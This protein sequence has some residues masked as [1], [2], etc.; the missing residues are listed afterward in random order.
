MKIK[1]VLFL[2]NVNVE[3]EHKMQGVVVVE[4]AVLKR[5]W[6]IQFQSISSRFQLNFLPTFQHHSQ[7]FT[8]SNKLQVKPEPKFPQVKPEVQAFSMEVIGDST[9]VASNQDASY[10]SNST[11]FERNLDVLK[12]TI[13]EEESRLASLEEARLKL[14]EELNEML[15]EIK[16][17]KKQHREAIDGIIEEREKMS[18]SIIESCEPLIDLTQIESSLEFFEAAGF[19]IDIQID[20]EIEK[21][22]CGLLDPHT[23]SNDDHLDAIKDRIR[24]KTNKFSD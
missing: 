15:E 19:K 10:E 9:L 4:T 8:D 3:F 7:L 5:F 12:T 16:Q 11:E 21:L 6:I 24:S 2:S 20:S 23:P 22:R 14:E 1:S 17:E 18:R 13:D